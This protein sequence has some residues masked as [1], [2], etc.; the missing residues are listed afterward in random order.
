MRV[1]RENWVLWATT[2]ALK[3]VIEEGRLALLVIRR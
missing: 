3:I 1:Q 2:Q